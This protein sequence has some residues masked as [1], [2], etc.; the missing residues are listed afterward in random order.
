[1]GIEF[2]YW[3]GRDPS[4]EGKKNFHVY[5]R[6]KEGKKKRASIA[7]E[8]AS[9]EVE[10]DWDLSAEDLD[11]LERDAFQKIAQLR[12]PT[13]SSPHQ[14]H[15]SATATTNHLPPKPL[16]DSRPQTVKLFSFLIP[17]SFPLSCL[18]LSFCR[19]YGYLCRFYV[20]CL[21][22]PMLCPI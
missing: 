2:E 19:L 12:N 13:P 6:E 10:D 4:Q 1:M 21:F 22:M 7:F 8:R 5:E 16:P 14:R 11:S 18:S 17:H 20:K 9:M 15:H 3:S